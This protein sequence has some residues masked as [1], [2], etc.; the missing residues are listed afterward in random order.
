MSPDETVG[1]RQS[2]YYF[3][4][5]IDIET[6]IIHRQKHKNK[7]KS[8]INWTALDT[9]VNINIATRNMCRRIIY[10]C[11]VIRLITS[12]GRRFI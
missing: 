9:Q 7:F 5:H 11:L 10:S 6:E 1:F 2:L 12:R 4:F 8:I 3:Q